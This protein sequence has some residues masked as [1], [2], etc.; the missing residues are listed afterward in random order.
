MN[1][2]LALTFVTAVLFGAVLLLP[3]TVRGQ[4]TDFTARNAGTASCVPT[5]FIISNADA[6]AC[7]TTEVSPTLITLVGEVTP[8]FVVQSANGMRYY[9]LPPISSTLTLLMAQVGR[10]FVV[11]YANGLRYYDL[12]PISS[13]LTSLMAQVGDRFVI[14]YANANRFYSVTY[15]IAMIGDTAPPQISTPPAIIAF[16]PDSTT[17]Q[18]ITDEF[19]TTVLKYGSQPGNYTHTLT[20]TLY[21]KLHEFTLTALTPGQRYYFRADHTDRSGNVFQSQEY[22]FVARVSVYLPLVLRR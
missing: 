14:Q 17:L 12:P 16:G 5:G 8:R 21:F 4:A 10:R 6:A 9:D 13:T 11:Q 7:V 1:P 2:K 22:N 20:D 19:A 15:P 3:S 18:W